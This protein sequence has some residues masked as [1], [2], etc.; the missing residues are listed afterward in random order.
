[1]A[2]Y[3][4]KENTATGGFQLSKV[5]TRPFS[6]ERTLQ[7]IIEDNLKLALGVAFITSEFTVGE[8]RMDTIGYDE[9]LKTFVII[10]YKRDSKY[11]VMDQGFT[12]LN[13]LLNRKADFVLA[14]NERYQAQK[15]VEEFDWSQIRVIFIAGAFNRYQKEAV[16]NPSQPI[17]LYEANLFGR[18][19]LVLNK[20]EK[21]N[22]THKVA[23]NVTKSRREKAT[24]ET[25]EINLVS[26]LSPVSEQNLLDKSSEE[27]CELYE[28]IKET[29]LE[30]D[31][32]FEIKPTKLYIGF[33]LNRH[34]VVD[35]LPLQK[36]VKIWLNLNQGQLEDSECFTRDVSNI[37]HW[38]NGEYEI[39]LENDDKLE[40]VLSLIK[41]AWVKH[42]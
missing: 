32:D 40:Y 6:K 33:R 36:K 23:N 22:G 14:Y 37:G 29:L 10:E 9:D 2:F 31:P 25:S 17:D 5:E 1:M 39:T 16:N 42:R 7:N 34:N 3:T 13:M 18:N 38:G 35:F 15:S 8:F 41:Q 21:N 27:V 12:Y 30:W 26:E 19:E 28:R 24:K 20:I 4:F 11:S